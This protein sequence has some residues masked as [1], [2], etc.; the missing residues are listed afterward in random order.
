MEVSKFHLSLDQMHV[1]IVEF[2]FGLHKLK[3][4]F[5]AK[6]VSIYLSQFWCIICEIQYHIQ[7]SSFYYL[8]ISELRM[9]CQDN[10]CVKWFTI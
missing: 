10:F 8:S 9:L 2:G 5:L 6:V 1:T 7:I 3:S 4:R